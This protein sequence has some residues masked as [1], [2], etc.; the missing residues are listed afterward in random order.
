VTLFG[1]VVRGRDP[2]DPDLDAGDVDGDRRGGVV[3][4]DA[5]AGPKSNSWLPIAAAV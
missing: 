4:R 1:Q 2:D 3:P 5:P